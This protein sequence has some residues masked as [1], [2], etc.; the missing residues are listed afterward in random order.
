MIAG[1]T[2]WTAT[3]ADFAALCLC[4]PIKPL[5]ELKL[6]IAKNKIIWFK[7]LSSEN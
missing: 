6:F 5:K 4:A 1:G 7:V 3:S 2:R